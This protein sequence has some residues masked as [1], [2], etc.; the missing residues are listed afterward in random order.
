MDQKTKHEV[1]MAGVGGMGIQM[2]GLLL[3]RAAKQEY[4]YVS[5]CPLYTTA[6]RFGDC[7]CTVILSNEKIASPLKEKIGELVVI[8]SSQLPLFR[9]RVHSDGL[10]LVEST[11]LPDEM[12]DWNVKVLKVPGVE[13]AMEIGSKQASNLVL[14]GAYIAVTKAVSPELIE[15]EL[16]VRFRGKESILQ[17]NKNAFNEGL[18]LGQTGNK[19]RSGRESKRE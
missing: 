17:L 10:I 6:M 13:K 9:E 11:G 4:K 1:I 7:E 15:Q 3:A 8:E 12:T 16:E 5:W 14:L 19:V 2:A 18:K